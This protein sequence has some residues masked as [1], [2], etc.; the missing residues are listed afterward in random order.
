MASLSSQLILH[1]LLNW[2]PLVHWY[3]P[4]NFGGG[5]SHVTGTQ[6]PSCQLPSWVHWV[7]KARLSGRDKSRD[8]SRTQRLQPHSTHGLWSQLASHVPF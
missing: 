1:S 2:K 6:A 3:S 8:I 4:W 5:G 7:L